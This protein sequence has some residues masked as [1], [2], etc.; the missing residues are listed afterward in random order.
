MPIDIRTEN[1]QPLAIDLH[2]DT[3]QRVLDEGADL[4]E[5]SPQ[6]H[7]DIPRMRA[8]GL[9]AQFF[10]IWVNPRHFPGAQ[11]VT[12]AWKLIEALKTQ[13]AR[14]PDD[15]ELAT[16]AADIERIN[17]GGRIAAAM[18]IEGGHAIN[19][20]IELVEEFFRAGVRYMTLSWSNSNE[21]CGSSGDEGRER[22]LSEFGREVVRLMNRLGMLVDI[23][24]VSDKAFY[25]TL[26]LTAKPAVC[27]HSNMRE[28]CH[29]PRNLTDDM[30]RALAQQGGVCCINFYPVFLDDNFSQ[31]PVQLN[32]DS[33]PA[34]AARDKSASIKA[35]SV[36]YRRVADHIERAVE[37]AGI[38][39]VGLGSDYDGIPSVPEGL[40]DISK[41]P[42]LVA[43][44]QR[45]NFDRTAI[46]KILNGNI[47]RVFAAMAQGD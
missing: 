17:A 10:S 45:R 39:H 19:G 27:S 42:T 15:L 41:L 5:V 8:G 9:G 26:D 47:M 33:A 3:L 30:L 35:P 16:A 40:E 1:S 28:I 21:I 20:R 24:H 12:R 31:L 6:G 36:N 43:E 7:I 37:I 38:D 11:A 4:G 22:G 18:G 46:E 34:N 23:S 2:A 13:I 29:H 25:E 14:H 44:L 32:K